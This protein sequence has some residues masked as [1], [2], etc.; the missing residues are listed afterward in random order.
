MSDDAGDIDPVAWIRY[1]GIPAAAAVE[2]LKRSFWIA[3]GG[4]FGAGLILGLLMPF[5]L[6]KLGLS[7]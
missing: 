7:A 3:S 1:V 5:I 4:I 6:K 2:A